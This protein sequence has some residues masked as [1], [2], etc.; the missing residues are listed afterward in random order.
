VRV[1]IQTS[2]VGP[3]TLSV[4]QF[5]AVLHKPL[6][7]FPVQVTLQLVDAIAGAARPMRPNASTAS[8]VPA[9]SSRLRWIAGLRTACFITC[10][11]PWAHSKALG[12]LACAS[13]LNGCTDGKHRRDQPQLT[14]CT[15]GKSHPQNPR[16]HG[17]GRAAH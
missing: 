1:G 10:L 15:G 4:L 3:G 16:N 17:A 6:P 9:A 11:A 14:V 7:A 13:F 5:E 12:T 8:T 2:L